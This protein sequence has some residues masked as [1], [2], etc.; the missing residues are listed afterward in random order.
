MTTLDPANRSQWA[1]LSNGD[2]S[3]NGVDGLG[4]NVAP[5]ASTTTR[6]SGK[7]AVELSWGPGTSAAV[8]FIDGAIT[9][10]PANRIYGVL[11]RGG[12]NID[13]PAPDLS[14]GGGVSVSDSARY[15]YLGGS[16]QDQAKD[17]VTG[18]NIGFSPGSFSVVTLLIDIGAGKL[19]IALDGTFYAGQD[20]SIGKGYSLPGGIASWQVMAGTDNSTEKANV[21]FSGHTYAFAG[22]SEWDDAGG[23]T[24]IEGDLA[25]TEIGGDS[26]AFAGAVRIAGA[27][28]GTETGADAAAMRGGVPVSGRFVAA[29]TGSDAVAM[30]GE[31][32]IAGDLAAQEDGGDIAALSGRVTISG[33]LRA[34]ETGNDS[35]AFRTGERAP[36]AGR[37]AAREAGADRCAMIG[38]V[39]IR[40]TLSAGESGGDTARF[41]GA[42]AVRGRLAATEPDNDNALLAGRVRVSG[43]LAAAEVGRDRASFSSR[44]PEPPADISNTGRWLALSAASRT[45]ALTARPRVLVA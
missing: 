4:G 40:G 12:S 13:G 6:D 36:I 10:D 43:A 26:A 1:T 27:L 9:L 20:P 18:A 45:L 22:F 21:R 14:R 17:C 25:A 33:T 11:G 37:L 28:A 2:L 32:G 30:A 5:A 15:P 19:Y 7:W 44:E 42:V 39:A 3:V 38:A 35:A 29:E 16:A 34:A 24:G 41:A 8:G 31:I 23:A